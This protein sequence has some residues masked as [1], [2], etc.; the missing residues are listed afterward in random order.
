M[1]T[2]KEIFITLTPD[3][4]PTNSFISSNI[5][6]GQHISEI[7]PFLDPAIIGKFYETTT[8]APENETYV[9]NRDFLTKAVNMMRELPMDTRRRMLAGMIFTVPMAAATMAAVGVPSLMIAPLATVIPGFLFSA[10]METD[11]A[12]VAAIRENNPPRRR[13]ISGLVDAISEFR[14]NHAN[15]N[16]GAHDHSAQTPGHGA[17]DHGHG[18]HSHPRVG[19]HNHGHGHGHGHGRKRST[20]RIKFL[21]KISGPAG[22]KRGSAGKTIDH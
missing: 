17:H 7:F 5:P 20:R 8:A 19:G 11:P 12:V 2:R 15:G 3:G 6:N 18:A 22:G 16:H 10:F 1:T 21:K 14:T 9:D 13:G 4:S